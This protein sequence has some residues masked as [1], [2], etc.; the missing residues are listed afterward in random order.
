MTSKIKKKEAALKQDCKLYS[1]LFVACQSRDG[2]LTDFFSHENHYYPP[3]ILEY[4]KLRS[5]AKSDTI[6]ILER[7]G[8]TK[9]ENPTSR[10]IVFDGAVIVQAVSPNVSNTFEQYC[11]AEFTK[12]I[13]NINRARPKWKCQ[14]W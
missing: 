3:A 8:I 5:T 2:D 10:A 6:T 7:Y 4:G 11:K 1:S 9:Y 14:K 12:Y 13:S